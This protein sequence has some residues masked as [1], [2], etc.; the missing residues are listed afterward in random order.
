GL[1]ENGHSYLALPGGL[2]DML[3]AGSAAVLNGGS[4]LRA[5][6]HVSQ[7]AGNPALRLLDATVSQ[8]NGQPLPPGATYLWTFADGTTASG[9][10]VRHPFPEAGQ[11]AVTLTVRLP[12]GTTDASQTRVAIAGQD[13]LSLGPDGFRAEAFDADTLFA[14]VAAGVVTLGASGVA[15]SIARTH[16]APV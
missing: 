8:F 1:G 2:L 9:P 4:G 14:P 3:D 12:D 5:E 10:V 15:A 16:L 6:F 13:V 7:E 11:H